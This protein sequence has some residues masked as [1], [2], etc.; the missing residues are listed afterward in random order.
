ME[1]TLRRL[2][3][4]ACIVSA[5][6]SLPR[7]AF[8]QGTITGQ[9][10]AEQ[11]Q[12]PLSGA[13]VTIRGTS[14]GA[15]T[16]AS[17]RFVLSNVPTGTAALEAHYLGYRTGE[18]TVQ[19][20]AG[21]SSEVSIALAEE[22]L[23]L[24]EIIVTGTPGGTQRRALGHDVAR[25]T[26]ADL[27]EKAPP[28]NVES[29][30]SSRS[31]GVNIQ[32][33]SG[34]I[35]SGS[36]IQIRGLGSLSLSNDPLII[37]DGVRVDNNTRGG[38][39][40]TREGRSMS[41]LNDF[42]PE[43]IESIE[44]IK[45]PAAATLYGT[46]ASAGVIQIITKRGA[47]GAPSFEATIRQGANFL[48][49]AEDRL[50][51][52]WAIDPTTGQLVAW[53]P[54][55]SELEAGYPSPFTT[56]P[57]QEYNLGLS[58][59]TDR[60]RYYLAGDWQDS[61][62]YVHW[63]THR[64]GGIRTNLNAFIGEDLEIAFSLGVNRSTTRLGDAPTPYSIIGGV[65]WGH[66]NRTAN[67]GWYAA[68]PEQEAEIQSHARL[69]RSTWSLQFNHNPFEWLTHRFVFGQD[70]AHEINTVLFER[71]PEGTLHTFGVRALGDKTRENVV[72]TYLSAD[73]SATASFDLSPS[74]AS[75][76]SAG[77]QYYDRRTETDLAQGREFPAPGITTLN[78]AAVTFGNESFVE[79]KSFGLY[80][81]QQL[82]WQNRI[83]LTGAVRGDDNSAFGA[84]YEAA[85]YP[86]VSL[87]WVV[88]DEDFWNVPFVSQFRLRGAWGQAGRQPDVFAAVS[89][90]EPVTG[91]GD[92]SALTPGS[93]GNPALGPEV[94]TELELGFEAALFNER[95]GVNF[96]VYDQTTRDA[97]IQVPVPLSSGYRTNQW[98]NLGEISNRGVELDLNAA[99]I[100]AR[101]FGWDMGLNF[102]TNRNRLVSLG[103]ASPI[104]TGDYRHWEGYPLG[105][106]WGAKVV[107]AE[108]DP[109]TKRAINAMCETSQGT[110]E[111]C[112]ALKAGPTDDRFVYLG[113]PAP[114]WMGA[115]NTT[116]SLGDNLRLFANVDY[117][118]GHI[119]REML[120]GF[121]HS[122]MGN[123]LAYLGDPANG[124]DPDPIVRYLVQET[125][126]ERTLHMH[127]GGFARLR[128]V[129]ATYDIPAEL[130]GRIRANRASINLAARNLWFLWQAQDNVFGEP[131]I[132]PETADRTDLNWSAM[133]VFYHPTQIVAS[134]NLRF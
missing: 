22:A 112:D 106:Q 114:T 64:R 45:G 98:V 6:L 8:A 103:G 110:V 85:L 124:V 88:S 26:T 19:V 37:V 35:G 9:V 80:V 50:P 97:L 61:E 69:N 119:R 91:P 56:G 29:I 125:A 23:S 75:Q 78:A 133:T 126:I 3:T 34:N 12:R 49:D 87:A 5:V 7:Q 4:V 107:S 73:Y 30:L 52:R 132:D 81:Q 60:L 21:S 86:K 62:G 42:N 94:G 13:T 31:A 54:I 105:S 100:Q 96:S 14:I 58:G 118:G 74:L 43:D 109:T 48:M 131:V 24:D 113:G 130:V 39:N 129:S 44:V 84:D 1:R 72:N 90:Y 2:L 121:A 120:M 47:S 111:S 71:Q 123:T 28:A 92:Q 93:I 57:H 10:V 41:R 59:G 70:V 25:V 15:L 17:G 66:A 116:I 68:T 67:R 117:K 127:D 89:L 102:S 20:A 99:L 108:W 36:R 53:H 115:I 128:E 40:G 32:S 63:N 79:N 38:A 65:G 83:F 104:G 77:I 16:N 101:R 55:R 33:A 95:L 134:L 27:L 51:D 122:V 82:A 18:A 11:T 76:T 46:E